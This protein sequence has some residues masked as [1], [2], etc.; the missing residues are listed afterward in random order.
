MPD[1]SVE[2]S[3]VFWVVT[4]ARERSDLLT[5]I[6]HKPETLNLAMS[7]MVPHDGSDPARDAGGT[8]WGDRP[9]EAHLHSE[10][11]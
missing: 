4:V 11:S 1:R 10:T 7:V 8:H 3:R 9:K 6:G 5:S 2:V